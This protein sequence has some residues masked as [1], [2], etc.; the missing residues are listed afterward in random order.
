MSLHFAAVSVFGPPP[1]FALYLHLVS[2]S[3]RASGD[4][5]LV[6][7]VA[8]PWY[9]VAPYLPIPSPTAD[10]TYGRMVVVASMAP[11]TVSGCS[12]MNVRDPAAAELRFA[13]KSSPAA[14]SGF[15]ALSE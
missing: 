11:P 15:G 9:V 13:E 4:I 3:A 12:A 2:S 7:N 5:K 8:A 1:L 6:T 14:G 10:T